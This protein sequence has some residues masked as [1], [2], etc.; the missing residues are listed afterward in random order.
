MSVGSELKTA[1][2][3][4][5]ITLETI[6]KKTKIPVK[7]LESLEQ[8][9]FDVFPS[10]VYAKSFIRAYS[11]IIGLDTS[12]M[13]RQFNSEVIPKEVRIEPA[14]AEAEME[15]G[16]PWSP[17][18]TLPPIARRKETYDDPELERL[19]EEDAAPFRRE[20]SSLR[21][22]RVRA[23]RRDKWLRRLGTAA[24]F[25]FGFALLAGVFYYTQ[26]GV[27]SIQWSQFLP[28]PTEETAPGVMDLNVPDKYQHLV[29][30]GLDKSWV[31]VVTDDGKS[32]SEVDMDQGDVKIYQAEKN[33]KIKIGNAGGVDI[34][35]NGKAL[36]VLGVT[37]QVV[38]IDLPETDDPA[39]ST[40]KS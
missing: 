27:A 38:E 9:Q 2:L 6:S 28:K 37:G 14:N 24:V 18:N 26:R 30:K 40:D 33:F 34:Q 7:Y 23:V 15:R 21:N 29:L 16:S 13:T 11:K 4:K 35:Y 12:V 17:I 19:R 22:K 1:R 10:Q 39:D 20:P 5:K 31:Q 3:A 36:G 25:V 8:D 32:T